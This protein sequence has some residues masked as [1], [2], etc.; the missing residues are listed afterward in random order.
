MPNIA[1]ALKAEISR[2]ARK[3]LRAETDSLRKA[4]TGYRSEIAALKRRLQALEKQTKRLGKGSAVPTRPVDEADD[5]DGKHRFSA[6]GFA[7]NRARL[8]LSAADYG[9]LLGVSQLSV[10]KWE[11][12]KVRPRAGYLPA[13]AEVRKLGKK[14]A[15]VRLGKSP[16]EAED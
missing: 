5:A 1:T 10:Y 7:A 11:S 3:E 12:G 8:R 14:E 13:I 16:M 2:V 4:V 6:K 15:A 9:K